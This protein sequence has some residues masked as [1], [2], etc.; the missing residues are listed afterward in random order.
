M[1]LKNHYRYS[2]SELEKNRIRTIEEYEE[3]Y[4]KLL[5]MDD[6]GK[7]T[8]SPTERIAHYHKVTSEFGRT[9]TSRSPEVLIAICPYCSRKVWARIRHGIFTLNASFWVMDYDDGKPVSKDSICEH[10]VF[11]DGALNLNGKSILEKIHAYSFMNSKIYMGAEVP[12][13]KPRMLEKESM[14]AILHSF[15]I[16]EKYTA[17]P[18][19]YFS[20]I[21]VPQREFATGWA[22]QEYCARDELMSEVTFSGKRKE[23]QDYN[24]SRW[25]TQN[26]IGWLTEKN[27]EIE[28]SFAPDIFPYEKIE[29]RMHP[30]F[31]QDG[32][33]I[34]LPNPQKEEISTVIETFM[35]GQ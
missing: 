26:K 20:K 6:K 29:G 19:T 9:I 10:L 27:E 24:L 13:I 23:P 31:I 7:E 18:V 16:A 25:V 32:K 33:V 2:T 11:V 17:F 30:F 34:D 35:P 14:V 1:K 28:L 15:T 12:F 3:T 8:P 21:K 4:K 5:E 22:R